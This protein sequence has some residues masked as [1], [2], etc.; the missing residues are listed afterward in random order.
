MNKIWIVLK[1]EFINTVSRRSFLLVLILVPLVPAVFVGAFSILGGEQTMEEITQIIQPS[2]DVVPS[3]GYIDHA[4][5]ITQLPGWLDEGQL[6]PFQKESDAQEALR[7][8]KISAFYI[9]GENYL[10]DG[11]IRYVQ[12]DF[13]P[14]SAIDTPPIINQVIQFNLLSGDQD[15]FLLFNQPAEIR[16]I[17]LSPEEEVRD[18][19]NPLAFFI[20][21]GITM[22]FYGLILS[23]ATL[24]LNSITKEKEN[25]VM[26]I[27]LSSIK[28]KQ[29]LTGKIFGLGLVGLLQLVFWMGSAI[30]LLRLSGRTF[31][32]PPQFQ[33][34]PS[35]F[36]W[37]IL[38]FLLGYLMYASIM[39]GVGSLIPNLK[40]ASQA[41]F[42][43]ILPLLIP[44]LMI[45]LIINQP[46][47]TLPVV[48]SLF[49]LTAPNT[50][51]TRLAIGPV[52]L[53]QLF[54]SIGLTC[55]TIILLIHGVAGMFRSQTLL[56]G[57]KFKFGLFLK[58][59]FGKDLENVR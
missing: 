51:I 17:N 11:E 31:D 9:I 14:L 45:G 16:R 39:A 41:T 7:S 15:R 59:L 5:I 26:E 13:N 36:I 50:M 4:G 40:E 3:E 10:Q 24:M 47:A 49:P 29:M 20:P 37:G 32:I 38:F 23:S 6:I 43:I 21:Y 58:V 19:T 44:L 8:E 1:T 25:R 46:D 35:L 34:P 48:L 18:M 27:L 28:P 12:S 55:L 56:T 54:I 42:I 33:L 53:W 57:N 22:L 30:I 52:P 2:P